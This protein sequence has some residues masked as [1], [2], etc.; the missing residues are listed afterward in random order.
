MTYFL[1]AGATYRVS[2][3][4]SLDLYESLPVGTYTVK[5]DQ[6]SNQF[7]LEMIDNFDL[8]Y[9]IYG[10]TPSKAER[11]LGTFKDRPG[12]TGV[13]LTGEKG[14]GKTLL[15]K[16]ISERARD[17]DIPTIVINNAWCGEEFNLFM[18]TIDQP[19]VVIFDEFE[20]VYDR[21]D[22]EKLLTLLDGV[23][24]SKKLFI[25]TCNDKYRV[26]EHM[27][28]RPG[29]IFYRLDYKGLTQEFITEYCQD[30][31]K[32]KSHIEAICRVSVLFGEFNFDMLKA[33]VEEMNRYNETP[34]EALE[35]LNAKPDTDE[36][37]YYDLTLTINGQEVPEDRL[38]DENWSGNP[39]TQE[40]WSQYLVGEEDDQEWKTARFSASDLIKVE[41]ESGKFIFANKE[42]AKLS[43]TR[44]KPNS[45]DY[46][47]AVM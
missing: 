41:A 5:F 20:K 46:W 14:S 4:A 21:E 42:G 17:M 29:R 47:S 39:L 34:Q 13:M 35:I 30:N 33:L 9:K 1:K 27:K 37:S 11:I 38:D 36:R 43:L 10:D 28:N 40:I 25:I 6:M 32:N 24:P 23:Y 18:Q 44:T 8:G 45:P 19:V 12:S 2:A 3:K 22:Q 7:Y 26:N 31:L 15:A 16:L